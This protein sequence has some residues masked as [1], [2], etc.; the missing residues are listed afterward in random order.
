M[1]KDVLLKY[2][3]LAI[4]IISLITHTNLSIAND[5]KPP[6]QLATKYLA[7]IEVTDYWVSEKLDGMRGYWTGAT[8]LS[9]QGKEIKAPF[10]FIDNWPKTPMDGELW[11]GREKF[12]ATISC[13]KRKN[14]DNNCWRNI[15]FMVFDLPE[16]TNNFTQRIKTMKKLVQKHNSP[17][18]HAI[19]Q[20]KITSTEALEDKLT[21]IIN[22]G[23]EGLMLHHQDAYYTKGRNAHLMKLKRYR[24]AEAR[25]IE[26]I[27][28]KGKYQGMLGSIVVETPAGIR[29]KI[30]SGFTDQQ[31]NNPPSIGSVITYKYTGKT[32][33]GVPRF[34]SFLRIR[35]YQ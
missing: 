10:W 16:N 31:R 7:S 19:K 35:E 18:L 5:S 11:L 29:F 15:K 23:G 26:H 3:F 17:Y 14:S 2:L 9:K 25:V 28:G 32:Q 4:F 8:L 12:Q 33:R 1:H 20:F 6:I 21:D 30:G 27:V 22:N 34:A 24:D 13:I